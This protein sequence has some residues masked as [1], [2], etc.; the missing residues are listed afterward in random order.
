MT[1]IFLQFMLINQEPML[2]IAILNSDITVS[3]MHIP[4]NTLTTG[5][6][7]GKEILLVIRAE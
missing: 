3:Q 2:L 1:Q 5:S 7:W 4:P 6:R